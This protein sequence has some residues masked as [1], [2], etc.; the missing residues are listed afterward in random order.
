MKKKLMCQ[1]L[2]GMKQQHCSPILCSDEKRNRQ[3]INIM[4]ESEEQFE[5]NQVSRFI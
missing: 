1:S 3:I 4:R 5:L 2:D